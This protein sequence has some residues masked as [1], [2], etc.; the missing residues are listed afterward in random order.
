MGVGMA[1]AETMLQ[2]DNKHYTYILAGD[3]DLQ[4]PI[5]LGCISCRPLESITIN[6]VYDK[7]DIK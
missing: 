3:G 7:N 5:A 4:E 1:V 2:R 6:Y